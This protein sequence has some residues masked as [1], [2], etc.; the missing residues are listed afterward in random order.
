MHQA[1]IRAERASDVSRVS[2]PLVVEPSGLPSSPEMMAEIVA[3]SPDYV[4]V[5]DPSGLIELVNRVDPPM[6]ATDVLGTGAWLHLHSTPEAMRSA[7]ARVLAGKTIPQRT[8]SVSTE[9]GERWF[10][11]RMSALETRSGKRAVIFLSDVT[12]RESA[13]QELARTAGQLEASRRAAD[14]A[15]KF[16]SLGRLAGG[17]AHDFNNLLTSIISFSRFVMDDLAPNDPR[18][19]DLVEVLRAADSA[20]KLTSQL[21]AFSRKRPVEPRCIDLNAAVASLGQLLGRVVGERIRLEINANVKNANVLIDPGQ[22]DQVL[23]NLAVNAKDAMPEGG[24]LSIM[25][26]KRELHSHSMLPPGEYVALSVRDT[27]LGMNADVRRQ[28]FEP[29]FTTKG[30]QGTGL[31][32]A[33]CYGIVRQA[34][35]NIEVESERGQGACFTVLLKLVEQQQTKPVE[36]SSGAVPRHALVNGLA[37]VVEDQAAIRRT[38]A[39]SLKELGLQVLE[40]GSA[41]EALSLVEDLNAQVDLLVTDVVL[42]GLTGV[43]LAEQLRARCPKLRVVVSSGYLGM[44]SESNNIAMQVPG[45]TFLPKPFTGRQLMSLVGSLYAAKA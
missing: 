44:E 8:F 13:Q 15:Q 33:T 39:R 4:F 3:Q 20:S 43:K 34:G 23:M 19:S 27:G 11:V 25:V 35:G 2:R 26:E 22:L 1:T 41:E 12:E 7:I 29:F 21:L 17:V 42:P 5:V 38:M 40:A 45:T 16:E 18:R 14:H 32:L 31:G 9:G 30:E 28:V 6:T 36:S 10:S 37:L 24:A